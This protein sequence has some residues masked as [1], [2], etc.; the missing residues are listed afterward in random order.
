MA[1]ARGW[2]QGRRGSCLIGRVFVWQNEKSSGDCTTVG[3]YLTV[4]NCILKD[5]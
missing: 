5:D 3:M 2:G 1:V 4:L